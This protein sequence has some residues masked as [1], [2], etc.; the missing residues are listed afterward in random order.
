MKN[1]HVGRTNTKPKTPGPLGE[2]VLDKPELKKP[3]SG[4]VQSRCN[5]GAIR[6]QLGRNQG[7]G[8]I[9]VQSGCNW[10]N[11][12][13]IRVQLG[14][15]QGA[16]R[17]NQGGQKGATP[18][19]CKNMQN[20]AQLGEPVSNTVGRVTI[21]PVCT[22]QK[23]PAPDRTLRSCVSSPG[24]FRPDTLGLEKNFGGDFHVFFRGLTTCEAL[25]PARCGHVVSRHAK[26]NHA[27]IIQKIVQL[28][29]LLKKRGNLVALRILPMR[30]KN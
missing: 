30:G 24:W 19:S 16:I 23:T 25:P 3:T 2:P 9:R 14:C 26:S 27:N 5:Q 4:R 18:K 10:A 15:N 11:Q 28:N 6:V 17:C 20:R 1:R 8:A 29:F 12:G 7:Q 22:A 13:A 21:N